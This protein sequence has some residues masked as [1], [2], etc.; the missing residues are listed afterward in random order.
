MQKGMYSHIG[1]AIAAIG[2]CEAAGVIGSIFT[3]PNIASWYRT[4]TLPSFA[5][6]SW[7]FAPVW[8]T[9]YFLMG[10]AL[11]LILIEGESG[12]PVTRALTIFAVQLILNTLWSFLF[13]GLRSPLLGLIGIVI[14]W[15]T[16]LL[17]IGEF[18]R[19]SRPAAYLLVPYIAWVTLATALNYGIW[20]LN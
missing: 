12:I 13:F 10:L 11:Y 20:A 9:L 3:T 5:P 15:F 8:I 6:P 16:I 19:I 18:Y 14:L 1:K 7:V 17:T 4:L 2:I